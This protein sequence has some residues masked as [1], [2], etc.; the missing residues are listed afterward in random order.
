MEEQNK[1]SE[2]ICEKCGI[3]ILMGKYCS[4]SCLE[5]RAEKEKTT[6]LA[7]MEEMQ[8]DAERLLEEREEN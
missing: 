1:D 3:P 6:V 2:V 8:K 5:I 7:L 4:Y